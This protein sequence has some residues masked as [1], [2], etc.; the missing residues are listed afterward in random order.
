MVWAL[1]AT[2]LGAVALFLVLDSVLP[3]PPRP[4]VRWLLSLP[5]RMRRLVAATRGRPAPHPGEPRSA[6]PVPAPDPFEA[7]Q[8]QTRLA[9]VSTHIRELRTADSAAKAHKLVAAQAAYDD[10]LLEACR[11]ADV[12]GVSGPYD[13]E[14]RWQVEQQLAEHGWTW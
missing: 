3:H 11:I 6:V 4:G 8:V 2:A 7:L 9:T 10:L 14:A 12:Q 13:D 5:G 1:V